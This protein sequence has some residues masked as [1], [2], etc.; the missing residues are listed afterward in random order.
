MESLE[1]HESFFFYCIEINSVKLMH[2][3]LKFLNKFF[4]KAFAVYR[5]IK[6]FKGLKKSQ[7]RPWHANVPV[8]E[9]LIKSNLHPLTQRTK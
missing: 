4:I 9:M 5:C 3:S 1:C 7:Q 8:E 2:S 6:A